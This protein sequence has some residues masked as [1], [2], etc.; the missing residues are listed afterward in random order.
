MT[1]TQLAESIKQLSRLERDEL[2]QLIISYNEVEVLEISRDQADLLDKRLDELEKDKVES[3]DGNE[4]MK[5]IVNTY[6]IIT[7]V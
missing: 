5:D 4:V 2:L 1:K 3:L 7:K 6:D